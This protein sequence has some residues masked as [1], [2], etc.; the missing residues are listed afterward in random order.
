[1]KSGVLYRNKKKGNKAF[2]SSKIKLQSNTD[3]FGLLYSNG[4]SL[5]FFT[6]ISKR[7]D[8][9]TTLPC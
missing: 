1:M 3:S 9:R 8:I 7:T 5:E 4:E 2:R 6:D